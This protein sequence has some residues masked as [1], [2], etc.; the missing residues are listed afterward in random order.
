VR[1]VKERKSLQI[2]AKE[3]EGQDRGQNARNRGKKV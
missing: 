1:D 2:G 3:V